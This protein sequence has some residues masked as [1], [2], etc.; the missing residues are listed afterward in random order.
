VSIVT[1]STPASA[2]EWKRARGRSPRRFARPV[3]DLRR[4]ARRDDAI[5]LER[6]L[7][8]GEA[9]ERRVG[10]DAFVEGH[11]RRSRLGDDRN[12]DDLVLEAALLGRARGTAVGLEREGVVLLTVDSPLLGDELGRD[13]LG[14]EVVALEH[15]GPEGGAAA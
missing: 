5:G 15:L 10:P 1:G 2:N 7:E 3:G 9:L 14:H 13:A 6:G 12:R 8:L 4:V 11:R